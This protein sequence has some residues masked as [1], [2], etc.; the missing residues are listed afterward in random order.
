MAWLWLALAIVSE[1]FGSTMLKL[2]E[3]FSKLLPSA[4]AVLGFGLAFY[5][6]SLALKTLPLGTAY[7]VWAG[8]GLVLTAIVS[9]LFFGTKADAM[10]LLGIAFILVG[11]V[12]LNA[13]SHM[14]A[15]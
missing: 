2:S 11:V 1:V 5:F 9:M 6:L 15:H 10:G 13:F 12:I 4:G 8:V 7:A 14:A 3:G